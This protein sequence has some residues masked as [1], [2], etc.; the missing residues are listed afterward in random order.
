VT[1]GELNPGAH[2]VAVPLP[3]WS[4]PASVTV[5]SYDPKEIERVR[6][7][8]MEIAVAIGRLAS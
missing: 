2:G 4:S 6:T 3:G 7:P 8:L 5:V 1:H